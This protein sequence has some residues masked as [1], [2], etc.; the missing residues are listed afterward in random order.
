MK[1][2]KKYKVDRLIKFYNNAASNLVEAFLVKQGLTDD[3]G[4]HISF[5]PMDGKYYNFIEV[6][7]YYLSIDDIFTD[8]DKN[9]EKGIFFEW[10]NYSIEWTCNGYGS[11]NY[12]SYLAGFRP[13]KRGWFND[14][15]YTFKESVKLRWYRMVNYRQ[16]K[17]LARKF[18]E[19]YGDLIDKK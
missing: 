18:K 8:M 16:N 14:F 19:E 12:N 11:V 3:D 10:Y 4:N 7:D 13:K 2:N 9:I 15:L 17:E 1:N 6:A 5:E